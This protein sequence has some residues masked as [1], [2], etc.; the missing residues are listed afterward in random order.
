M[1]R[2][3]INKLLMAADALAATS[4]ERDS[5]LSSASSSVSDETCCAAAAV[6]AAGATACGKG[7]CRSAQV[8]LRCSEHHAITSVDNVRAGLNAARR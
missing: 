6:D 4:P 2:L 8:R 5:A 3:S 7:G 1:R